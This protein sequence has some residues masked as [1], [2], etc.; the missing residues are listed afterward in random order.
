M[1]GIGSALT[2]MCCSQSLQRSVNSTSTLYHHQQQQDTSNGL[3]RCAERANSWVDTA[4]VLQQR[5]EKTNNNRRPTIM[6]TTSNNNNNRRPLT[7]LL[8]RP[9]PLHVEGWG[10]ARSQ[11]PRAPATA[12]P[13]PRLAEA[14]AGPG[15]V[16]GG[17]QPVLALSVL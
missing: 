11:R 6:T 2:W 7:S 14:G 5:N 17:Y 13:P 8:C 3:S 10:H 9:P 16:E 1:Q 4:K 12:G 15:A